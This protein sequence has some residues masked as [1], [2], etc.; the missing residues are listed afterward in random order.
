MDNIKLDRATNQQLLQAIENIN[1][2]NI[3]DGNYEF[4]VGGSQDN[5]TFVV[6]LK[7]GNGYSEPYQAEHLWDYQT[8]SVELY[9]YQKDKPEE[10]IKLWVSKKYWMYSDIEPNAE[11]AKDP[12]PD[13]NFK[14]DNE[15]VK[16]LS[17]DIFPHTPINPEIDPNFNSQPWAKYF[18][19]F[20]D[21]IASGA[22]VSTDITCQI[23]RYCHDIGG[24]K[25]FW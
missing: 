12:W 11:T 16:F 17:W 10:E 4:C 24:L 5:P 25:A 18:H 20:S 13:N 7:C 6:L 15:E 22:L 1:Q 14:W 8:I 23:I 21:L 9:Y 3:P 19:H 2:K